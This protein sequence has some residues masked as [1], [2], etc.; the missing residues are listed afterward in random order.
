MNQ[1]YII[2]KDIPN[3]YKNLQQQTIKHTT[4]DQWNG[5]MG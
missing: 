3:K 1:L 2:K 5:W 4:P